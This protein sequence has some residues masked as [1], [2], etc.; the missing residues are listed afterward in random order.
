[1]CRN[2]IPNH[3]HITSHKNKCLLYAC[4]AFK[5][6]LITVN[7]AETPPVLLCITVVQIRLWM[8]RQKQH[9][10]KWGSET[11][12]HI[13]QY[14]IHANY[15][16]AHYNI[17]HCAAWYMIHNKKQHV[18]GLRGN[19]RNHTTTVMARTQCRLLKHLLEQFNVQKVIHTLISQKR[20]TMYAVLKT[21]LIVV[22]ETSA[23]LKAKSNKYNRTNCEL[24]TV[25]PHWNCHK[26]E[27]L[28]VQSWPNWFAP[29]IGS[30]QCFVLA[31]VKKKYIYSAYT[32][33]GFLLSS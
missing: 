18:F 7:G 26:V 21:L 14:K 32:V 24:S 2:A 15:V 6:V 19:R 23:V 17:K 28:K 22:I 3:I 4:W 9:T 31:S 27:P 8:Q 29:H 12:H 13:T 16:A 11:M 20:G 33:F 5:Q 25:Q 10:D 30:C 1:M